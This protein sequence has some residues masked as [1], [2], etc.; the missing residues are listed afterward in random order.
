VCEIEEAELR[1]L[2][3]EKPYATTSQT[4]V[5]NFTSGIGLCGYS[6]FLAYSSSGCYHDRIV[7]G[8]AFAVVIDAT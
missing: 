6:S 3:E 4:Q 1:I 8:Y 2:K 5:A 7:G